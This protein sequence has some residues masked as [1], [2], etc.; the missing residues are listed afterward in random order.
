LVKV[1]RLDGSEYW[2]NP[3]Q[4]EIIEMKPDTIITLLSGRK[5]V[6]KESPDLIINCIVDYRRKLGVLGNEE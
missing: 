3:H 6:V 2:L 5:L 4:I 1:T